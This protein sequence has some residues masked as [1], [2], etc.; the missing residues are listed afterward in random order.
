M[1]WN[2]REIISDLKHIG[3]EQKKLWII[4][5]FMNRKH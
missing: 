5:G 4:G 2:L 1:R 3:I